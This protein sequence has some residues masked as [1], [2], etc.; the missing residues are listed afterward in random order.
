MNNYYSFP[1]KKALLKLTAEGWLLFEKGVL[2]NN[3]SNLFHL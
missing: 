1:A 2:V 3:V